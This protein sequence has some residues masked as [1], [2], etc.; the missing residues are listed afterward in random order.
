MAGWH[1]SKLSRTENGLREV[2][3]QDVATLLTAWNLPPKERDDVLDDLT[4][5]MPSGW[6]DRG[7]PGVP[8]DIGTLASYE[9]GA[10]ELI[11][12]TVSAVPGLLQTYETAVGVMTADGKAETDIEIRW[13]ARLRR[14]QLLG[15]VDYTTF[16]TETALRTPWGGPDAH[17]DQLTHLLT[18]Q[19]AGMG[20]RVVPD[21][22]T[23]VLLLHTW[24]C[25]RFH[26]TPPVVYVE[27]A[28]GGGTYIHDA[29]RFLTM[30]D[31]LDRVALPKDG[32]R[33][34]ISKLTKE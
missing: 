8:D 4:T 19:D 26:S 30:L 1:G 15:K 9:T 32:S 20:V 25:M 33:R 12:V 13:M 31:Q 6:W 27:M 24:T 34:F 14:K 29:Q 2:T 10:Y 16:V 3:I 28:S 11:D 21:R 5:T 17:R 7:I 18:A 23:E 22:Q